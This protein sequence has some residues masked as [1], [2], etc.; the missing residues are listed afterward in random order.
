MKKVSLFL[1]E[2][3]FCITAVFAV[4]SSGR[5]SEIMN[6]FYSGK[7]VNIAEAAALVETSAC[8]TDL[9]EYIKNCTV[10]STLLVSDTDRTYVRLLTDFEKASRNKIYTSKNTETIALYAEYLYSKLSWEK[11]SFTIIEQLPVWYAKNVLLNND[12]KSLLDMAV[13]YISA[14]NDTTLLWNSFIKKQ[15]YLID[16]LDLSDIDRFNYY[17][18]YSIFYMKMPD[19]KKGLS[20]LAR[21]EQLFPDSIQAEII[22]EN[23][24]RGRFG[25]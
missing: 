17:L 20:Y 14:A 2:V 19:T 3:F 6:D 8:G 13:W 10:L 23:Y 1:S 24:K 25:W 7:A 16:D 5:A 4:T 9:N 22:E 18:S 12:K 11:S 21:A 15:E